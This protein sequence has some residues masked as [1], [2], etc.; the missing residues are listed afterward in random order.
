MNIQFQKDFSYEVKSESS[1]FSSGCG[2]K[3]GREAEAEEGRKAEAGEWHKAEAE[4]GCK[5][6]AEEGHEAEAEEGY[7]EEVREYEEVREG[8]VTENASKKIE[9][10]SNV[11]E[12]NKNTCSMI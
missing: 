6:E 11:M 7:E 4:E 8:N 5:T 2:N 12:T 9:I 1:D 10:N 3:E